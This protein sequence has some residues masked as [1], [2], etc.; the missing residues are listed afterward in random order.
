MIICAFRL[1]ALRYSLLLD[2]FHNKHGIAIAVF[3]KRRSNVKSFSWLEAA[4]VLK[5]T[6]D[7]LEVLSIVHCGLDDKTRPAG[8]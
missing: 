5:V 4:R 1:F 7:E 2:S 6:V 8:H 3:G